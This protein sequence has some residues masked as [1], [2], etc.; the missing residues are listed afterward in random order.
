MK[1]YINKIL[2]A[3]LNSRLLNDTPCKYA[4][5]NNLEAF[6]YESLSEEVH[7]QQDITVKELLEISDKFKKCL[8]SKQNCVIEGDNIRPMNDEDIKDIQSS[9]NP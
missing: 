4:L 3:L 2:L 1:K 8:D 7:Q 5:L 9:L 6:S